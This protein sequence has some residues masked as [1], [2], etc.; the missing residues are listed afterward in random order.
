MPLPYAMIKIIFCTFIV[1]VI[2]LSIFTSSLLRLYIFRYGIDHMQSAALP[3][4]PD[5]FSVMNQSMNHPSLSTSPPTTTPFSPPDATLLNN[6]ALA[7][8][9]MSLQAAAPK[10]E[11]FWI[12]LFGLYAIRNKS[13]EFEINKGWMRLLLISF[14]ILC[15]LFELSYFPIFIIPLKKI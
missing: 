7:N 13:R 2:G 3:S 8:R 5:L 12:C 1:M 10:V 11:I 15:W 9:M 6:I 4:P 14:T